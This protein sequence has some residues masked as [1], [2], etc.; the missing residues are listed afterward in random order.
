MA[1]NYCEVKEDGNLG[2]IGPLPKSWGNIS[3]F[4]LMDDITLKDHGWLPMREVKVEY[5]PMTH[6]L[7]P[8][9][10]DIKE[11]EVVFTDDPH[12]FT[13]GE[14]AQ[15]KW[16]DW[17]SAMLRTDGMYDGDPNGLPRGREDIMDAL[18]DKYPGAFDDAKYTIIKARR[19]AKRDLRATRPS[20][21][22]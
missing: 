5:D 7:N 21:P 11:D 9:I 12:A 17:E 10:I 8:S 19:Q 18:D 3:A 13:D 14:L 22:E 2:W 15:N 20:Q 1:K 4:N 6:N 16:N